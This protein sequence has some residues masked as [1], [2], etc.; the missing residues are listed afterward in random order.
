MPTFAELQGHINALRFK[1]TI[2]SHITEYL[3]EKFLPEMDQKPER[4][5]LTEERVA[6]P[7]EAFDAVAADLS[8]WIKS[9]LAEEQ[10]VLGSTVALTPPQPPPEPEK[11]EAAPEP[12]P[13]P[14]EE[15]S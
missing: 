4:V 3:D 5:L 2:L 10:K 9:L 11:V 6:V 7:T 12:A 13:E 14:V 8:T 1:R 15:K